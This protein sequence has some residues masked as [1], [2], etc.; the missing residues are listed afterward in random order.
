MVIDIL[1]DNCCLLCIEDETNIIPHAIKLLIKKSLLNTEIDWKY[2]AN[3][4]NWNNNSH[5]S[6]VAS[7]FTPTFS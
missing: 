5:G 6:S 1:Q 4:V 3:I 7:V 2:I